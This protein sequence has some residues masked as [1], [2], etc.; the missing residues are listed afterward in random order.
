MFSF[1]IFVVI[2]TAVT[3]VSAS[4]CDMHSNGNTWWQGDFQ[5]RCVVEPNAWR[6]VVDSEFGFSLVMLLCD[7]AIF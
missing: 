6:T 2:A 4:N 3:S 1:L 5:M 7:F